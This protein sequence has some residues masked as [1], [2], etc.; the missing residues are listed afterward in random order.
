MHDP[1]T[2]AFEVKAPRLTPYKHAWDRRSRWLRTVMTVWHRDPSGYDSTTCKFRD[3]WKHVHHWRLQINVWQGFR[4]RHLDRCAWCGQ[5][6]S[7]GDYVNLGAGWEE[8]P[9]RHWWRHTDSFH[10]ECYAIQEAHN[11]CLCPGVE[12]HGPG[13]CTRCGSYRPWRDPES[14]DA[15]TRYFTTRILATIP[16]GQRDAAKFAKVKELW[17]EYREQEGSDDSADDG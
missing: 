9:G 13:R 6:S 5:G 10:H 15:L 11:T 7:K 3:H 8:P 14:P 12:L 1:L 4:L 17:A 16:V 2:V